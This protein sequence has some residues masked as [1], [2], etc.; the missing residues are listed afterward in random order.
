V[1]AFYLPGDVAIYAYPLIVGLGVSFGLAWV[2]WKAPA[3]ASL[4]RVNAGLWVLLGGLIGGRIAFVVINWRYYAANP[5]ETLQVFQGGLAWP[6]VLAGALLTLAGFSAL[7]R[8]SLGKLADGLIPLAATLVIAAWLGCWLEGCAYGPVTSG[9]WGLPASDEW[10]K[11]TLRFPTQLLGAVL[12]LATFW[13]LEYGPDILDRGDENVP[14]HTAGLG[15]VMLALEIFGL[16]FLRADPALYWAGMRLDAWA[17]LG[18]ALVGI[19]AL[20]LISRNV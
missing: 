8:Q 2:A 14:G 15:L 4:L 17:A 3:K 5:L 1:V 12:A 18:F 19:L 7:T 20:G 9:W 13:L 11:I 10:G 16:S 6:G